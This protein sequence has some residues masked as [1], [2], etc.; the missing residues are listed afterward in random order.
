MT[1]EPDGGRREQ[2]EKEMETQRVKEDRVA[3]FA[4]M[5]LER[6]ADYQ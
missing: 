4:R 6:Y 5:Q 3:E 1:Q 2:G